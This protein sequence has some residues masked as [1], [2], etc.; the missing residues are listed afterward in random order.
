VERFCFW[1]ALGEN[2]D[3]PIPQPQQ[4]TE[5]MWRYRRK[6]YRGRDRRWRRFN[7]YVAPVREKRYRGRVVT[8]WLDAVRNVLSAC[9]D[10]FCDPDA[11]VLK[12]SETSTVVEAN[13]SG[14]TP[15]I[16]KRDNR[17]GLGR[18]VKEVFLSS[19]AVRGWRIGHGLL[20]RGIATAR[21]VAVL[22]RRVCGF[23]LDSL[24]ATEKIEGAIR[25]DFW[26]RQTQSAN[27]RRRIIEQLARLIERMHYLGISQRDLKAPN[28]LVRQRRGGDLKLYLVDLDGLRLGRRVCRRRRVQNLM[29]LN[30]SA[31]EIGHISR[32]DR[33]RFLRAYLRPGQPVSPSVNY[34]RWGVESRAVRDMRRWWSQ[35][36]EKSAKK[37]VRLRRRQMEML[38]RGTTAGR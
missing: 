2:H 30:V 36:A 14:R 3:L 21:P 13:W 19:R 38:A 33:L 27:Q 16:L 23:L 37:W 7:K 10:P 6:F 25:L 24:L 12:H 4:V 26:V 15:I 11:K 34:Q 9:A 17:P 20:T 5:A 31:D 32:T 35:I 22:E 29:R 8:D 18:K 1:K 28:V